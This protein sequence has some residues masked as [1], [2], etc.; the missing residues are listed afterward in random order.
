MY[1]P[2]WREIQDFDNKF[3]EA[4]DFAKKIL[5]REIKKT[6]DWIEA[7]SIIIKKFKDS[8]DKRLVVFSKEENFGRELIKGILVNFDDPLYAVLP[9]PD[10]SLWHIV[11]INK[12]PNTYLSRKSLPKNWLGKNKKELQEITNVKDAVFCHRNGFMCVAESKEGA[13]AL[14]K[15]ALDA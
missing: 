3:T 8:N 1:V 6:K 5:R 13:I 9:R 4:V 15:K 10:A 7:E 2:T 11:A 12:G 14:A